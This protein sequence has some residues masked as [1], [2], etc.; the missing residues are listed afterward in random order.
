[1]KPQNYQNHARYFPIF[2]Y[3]AFPILAVYAIRGIVLLA[4]NPSLATAGAAAVAVAILLGVFGSRVMVLKVQD[5]II[6]LE[7]RLR[8]ERVLP[9]DMHALIAELRA[10]HLVALRFASDAELPALVRRVAQGELAS[11]KDIKMAVTD[12]QPDW[13]RA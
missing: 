13:F 6:R 11:Q 3:F 9:P 10:K 7:M 4:R 5:R 12:W 8:L 1:M 2:H